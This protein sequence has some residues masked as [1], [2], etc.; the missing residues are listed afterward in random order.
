NNQ[1]NNSYH[2]FSAEQLFNRRKWMAVIGAEANYTPNGIFGVGQFGALPFSPATLG[3]A[4]GTTANDTVVT[5]QI[6]RI[7]GSAF[8][9]LDFRLSPNN[10]L[11]FGG[12][13]GAQRFPDAETL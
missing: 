6:G 8:G 13:F 9:E 7:V 12:T 2:D 3:F 5:D 10:T 4:T 11:T 1:L